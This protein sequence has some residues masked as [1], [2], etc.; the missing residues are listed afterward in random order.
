MTAVT[1]NMTKASEDPREMQD[2]GQQVKWGLGKLPHLEKAS[3]MLPAMLSPLSQF[4]SFWTE[5]KM[6]LAFVK[7]QV[8]GNGYGASRWL[9]W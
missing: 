4:K 2:K 3:P 1:Q 6:A 9:R 8:K 7:V 5:S